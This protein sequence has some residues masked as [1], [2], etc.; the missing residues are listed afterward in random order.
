MKDH[1][2][3]APGA[4][5][6]ISIKTVQMAKKLSFFFFFIFFIFFIFSI[7]FVFV[8]SGGI[9]RIIQQLNHKK[10]KPKQNGWKIRRSI[11]P[12]AAHQRHLPTGSLPTLPHG[13]PAVLECRLE[14]QPKSSTEMISC[15]AIATLNGHP[16]SNRIHPKLATVWKVAAGRYFSRYE[17]S[18]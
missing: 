12:P 11:V 10:K 2:S 8:F 16:D 3:P 17:M 4:C 9:H 5:R 15:D 7:F 6:T 13:V 14:L 18:K 1:W